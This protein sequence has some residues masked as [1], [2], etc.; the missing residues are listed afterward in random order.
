MAAHSHLPSSFPPGYSVKAWAGCLP[1]YF[2]PLLFFA[3]QPFT[4]YGL[5][6]TILP[7]VPASMDALWTVF[8]FDT[9]R[10]P[11]CPSPYSPPVHTEWAHFSIFQPVSCM[12]QW[13]KPSRSSSVLCSLCSSLFLKLFVCHPPSLPPVTLSDSWSETLPN[14]SVN[15]PIFSLLST[16]NG[17]ASLSSQYSIVAVVLHFA[18]TQMEAWWL[19]FAKS[20]PSICC[21]RSKSQKLHNNFHLF[22][23]QPLQDLQQ[24]VNISDTTTT[25][26]CWLELNIWLSV[27]I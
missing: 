13:T 14:L 9:L 17:K 19:V 15:P 8:P 22:W 2:V 27:K 5:S 3:R 6:V 24:N 7:R 1:L 16:V 11:H 21:P 23:L 12:L 10:L 4:I 18:V 20:F 25:P 26:P